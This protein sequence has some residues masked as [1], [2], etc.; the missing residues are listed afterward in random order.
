MV[1]YPKKTGKNIEYFFKVDCPELE[2]VMVSSIQ[3]DGDMESRS[4][5]D[6]IKSVLAGETADF[7]EIIRRYQPRIFGT[8]RKYARRES[9]VDDIAQEVFIKTFRK[10]HTWRA[11]APF[12]HWIMRLSVR[13]CYDFLRK[14]QRNRENAFTDLSDPEK[15]WLQDFVKA[16][17]DNHSEK[18]GAGDLVHTLMD[19]MSPA[20]KLILQL[21]EIE[22]KSVK[23]IAEITGW[24]ISLVKVRAFRARNEMRK[25]LE[26]IDLTQYL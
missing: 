5:A 18:Q 16:P 15:D 13:T 24:S 22:Q 3:G 8:I 21:Q 6:I 26:K 11:E 2:F 10:L 7:E 20:G 19:Q 4:D 12:E 1:C 17:D 9:E 23:E 14:H 25:H